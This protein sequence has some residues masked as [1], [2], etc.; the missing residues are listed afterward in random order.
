VFK[1]N[2]YPKRSLSPAPSPPVQ[3]REGKEG[4]CPA[5][6]KSFWVASLHPLLLKKG[7]IKRRC[8]FQFL[9]NLHLTF[10]KLNVNQMITNTSLQES[11]KKINEADKTFQPL[12]GSF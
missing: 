7:L 2:K 1:R 3:I 6:F 5:L 12:L 11:N 10:M 8:F 4:A 9:I